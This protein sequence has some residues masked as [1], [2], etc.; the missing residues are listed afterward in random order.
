MN[1][2]NRIAATGLFLI[3]VLSSQTVF[4]QQILEQDELRLKPVYK[5]L[6]E[7]LAKPDS[8]YRLSLKGKKLKTFPTEVFQ[9]KNLNSLDLS[10]NKLKEIPDSL[11]QFTSLVELNLGYNQLTSLPESVGSIKNLAVLKL[12]RNKITY[13]PA[14]MGKL[15]YLEELELWDNEIDVFPEEMHNCKLLKKIDLRGI[16]MSDEK[17]HAIQA[18]FPNA[19]INF[20]PSCS[21]KD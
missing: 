11:D 9:F 17:Q 1:F 13:L 6:A 15:I 20:S 3:L 4:A 19:R 10:R 12:Y 16:L 18:L 2:Q 7:A 21:C 14:E 8:V 5:S